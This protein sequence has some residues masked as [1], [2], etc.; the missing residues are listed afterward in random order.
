MLIYKND[1]GS[2]VKFKIPSGDNKEIPTEK[3]LADGEEF[4]IPKEQETEVLN[5]YLNGSKVDNE[6]TDKNDENKDKTE[7]ENT[8]DNSEEGNAEEDTGEKVEEAKLSEERKALAEERA[9]LAE[10]RAEMNFAKLCEEGRLVPAQ[11]DAYMALASKGGYHLAEGDKKTVAELL[12]DFIMSAPKRS[13]MEE[14][15]KDGEGDKEPEITPEEKSV[16]EQFG[17]TEEELKNYKG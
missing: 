6:S 1:S 15:G 2:E 10:E 11:K 4:V 13:L 9:K 7:N 14:E 12:N 17:N 16:A 5:W 3:V 8:E